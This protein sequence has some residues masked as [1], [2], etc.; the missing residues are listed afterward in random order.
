MED[1]QR[2]PTDKNA[3]EFLGNIEYYKRRAAGIASGIGI[4]LSYIPSPYT[5][6]IG[7]L[8]TLPDVE[9]DYKNFKKDPSV[10][11]STSL[12]LD[13]PTFSVFNKSIEPFMDIL[14]AVDDF[15]N[16]KVGDGAEYLY[17]KGK[18]LYTKLFKSKNPKKTK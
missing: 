5:K 9:Y 18:E 17:N 4:G 2:I 10:A 12:A 13:I 7:P 3:L 15:T 8:M 1:L 16:G 6:I 11:S 14:G